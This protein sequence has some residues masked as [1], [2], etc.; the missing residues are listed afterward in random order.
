MPK[1]QN[2][3][4][5]FLILGIV[6]AEFLPTLQPTTLSTAYSQEDF[7]PNQ[8]ELL[9]EFLNDNQT[10]ELSVANA[11]LDLNLYQVS[12]SL[13]SLLGDI[14]EDPNISLYVSQPIVNDPS[15]PAFATPLQNQ[16][17]LWN[18][19][20]PIVNETPLPAFAV[21]I[22]DQPFVNN[23]IPQIGTPLFDAYTQG[24][25][26]WY[27]EN[28]KVI[29]NFPDQITFRSF[30]ISTG[31]EISWLQ[32]RLN[33]DALD[34]PNALKNYLTNYHGVIVAETETW[35]L[36]KFP[37]G[38]FIKISKSVTPLSTGPFLTQQ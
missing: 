2:L 28:G 19:D 27:Q 24:G 8:S 6:Y 1:I 16:P 22:Q 5:I 26:A 14:S 18:N 33:Y 38:G 3:L 32:D 7:A 36:V 10:E 30:Q 25:R 37:S 29:V 20:E 31:E 13:S 12:D 21:P 15:I 35:A 34:S 4:A 23:I 17:S 11:S 9:L